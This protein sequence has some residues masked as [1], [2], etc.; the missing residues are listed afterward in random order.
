MNQIK[1]AFFDVDGT[2]LS[3]KTNQLSEKTK[4]AV[5]A[6]K[7]NGIKVV[8]ATGR[9][10]SLCTELQEI[11]IESFITANGG[12]A[13]DRG[14]VIHQTILDAE[15]V[16]SISDAEK[17]GHGLSYMTESFY[18]NGIQNE[19]FAKTLHE[20]LSL[21]DYPPLG[22]AMDKQSIYLLCLY[23][24]KEMV[25]PYIEHFPQ[26]TF[27]RW[28]DQVV[29]VLQEDVSKSVAIKKMLGHFGID[30]ANAIAFGDGGND[31]DMIDYVGFGVAMGNGNSTLK[32][33]AQFVTKK[34]SEDGVSYALQQLGL[35]RSDQNATSAG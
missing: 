32:A 34:A 24:N 28:H 2:L 11:G 27:S 10:L 31:I 18:V 23:G 6:L 33:K 21:T 5:A 22:E 16:K 15:V 4:E 3:E 26:L 35:I 8:A 14:Q 13:I 30:R 29:N 25:Q 20:T 17:A 1:I 19:T 12:Y 9:P 7:A